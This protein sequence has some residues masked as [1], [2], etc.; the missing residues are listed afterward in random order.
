MSGA[1]GLISHLL[2]GIPVN[3]SG[4]HDQ[5]MVGIEIFQQRKITAR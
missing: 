4:Q 5:R 2:D 3:Q 1:Y